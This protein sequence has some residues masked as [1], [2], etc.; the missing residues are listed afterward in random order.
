[1]EVVASVRRQEELRV[2][3]AA[4]QRGGDFCGGGRGNPVVASSMQE[5]DREAQPRGGSGALQARAEGLAREWADAVEQ[6]RKRAVAGAAAR[7]DS[8]E[9]RA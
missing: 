5:R 7:I 3:P 9:I 2:E 6:R 8:G 4:A 1:M